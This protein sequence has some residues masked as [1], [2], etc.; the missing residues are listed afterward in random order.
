M[1]MEKMM[2]IRLTAK[3]MFEIDRIV[4]MGCKDPE[5]CF[6]RPEVDGRLELHEVRE[7]VDLAVLYHHLDK[8]LVLE[9][10]ELNRAWNRAAD[11]ES[12]LI[13]KVQEAWKGLDAVV[14]VPLIADGVVRIDSLDQIGAYL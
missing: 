6:G 5:Q 4:A 8:K 10:N 9:L 7:F 14:L 3:E 2:S 11:E 13:R 1:D 12:E